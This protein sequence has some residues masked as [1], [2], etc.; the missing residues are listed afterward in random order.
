MAIPFY[1][2][3][4][5]FDRS[6]GFRAQPH[7]ACPSFDYFLHANNLPNNMTSRLLFAFYVN[8]RDHAAPIVVFTPSPNNPPFHARAANTNPCFWNLTGVPAFIEI[9]ALTALDAINGDI[10]GAQA[11]E[12]HHIIANGSNWLIEMACAHLHKPLSMDNIISYMAMV[13]IRI[14]APRPLLEFLDFASINLIATLR[15]ANVIDLTRSTVWGQYRMSASSVVQLFDMMIA[16]YGI[17]TNDIIGIAGLNAIANLRGAI[18]D[19]DLHRQINVIVIAKIYAA[20]D[21]SGGVPENWYSGLR[22]YNSI[23]NATKNSWRAGFRRILEIRNNLAGLAGMNT[24][25]NVIDATN[26]RG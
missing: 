12:I 22:S 3:L 24:L 13:R 15:H 25:D 17:I 23:N 20:L 11:R 26:L 19:I 8:L 16:D 2:A 10:T 7:I 9:G 1:T 14:T 5:E 21:A 6:L 18:W 4:T